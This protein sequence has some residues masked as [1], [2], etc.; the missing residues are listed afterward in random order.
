[1]RSTQ[2]KDLP[3]IGRR[4]TRGA[5]LRSVVSAVILCALLCAARSSA[6]V[7]VPDSVLDP[8]TAPE[9]WNV[10]RLA[11]GNVARLL[12]EHRLSEVN[13][14]LS[15]CGPALRVLPT[16]AAPERRAPVAEQAVLGSISLGSLAQAVVAGDQRAAEASFAA[17][18]TAL[19]KLAA[20]FDPGTVGADIF[21]CP[22][23]PDCL[24]P[25]H[26]ATCPRCGMA[27]VPRR[28]PYSFVYV[29]P[30]EPSL[31]LTATPEHPLAAGQRTQVKIRLTHR[32][33]SPVTLSDLT[34]THT[35]PIHLL[36]VDPSLEDY[37]HEHP[38]PTSTPGEYTFA[39]TPHGDTSYRVFA[40]VAPT[41]SG[42]Q[43]YLSADLPGTNPTR[44]VTGK[45]STFVAA[46]AG[47]TFHLAIED[48][49]REPLHAQR[50]RNLRLT[51]RGS[52]G[53]PTT[54]LEP[55]MAAFAHL[56]GFY[57]DGRTVVH[58]HPAGGE[59]TDAAQR[60]GPSLDFRF[61]PPK[62]GFLRL[63]VQIQL[64]GRAVFAPFN[65]NVE[66]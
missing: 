21:F 2:P 15:L 32:D 52:D 19:E 50:P 14:Q 66:P 61:Y 24:S 29:P 3:T 13:D 57:E 23:H 30:G 17:L 16:V 55:V 20:S 4:R 39:F 8:R 31:L 7:P 49:D 47:L 33:G 26:A 25:D 58:L 43:E 45:E 51:V 28:I 35:Q 42:V 65:L 59:I 27:L 38:T 44:A 18:R 37:H 46:S 62:A 1:M 54:R 56:V 41:A 22:M 34:V 12:T 6:H 60:G 64:D 48:L 40:D 53:Q 63:Y 36:I 10:L 11:T 9:A 5:A